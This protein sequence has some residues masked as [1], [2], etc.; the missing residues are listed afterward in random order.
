MS[1]LQSKSKDLVK[2][3]ALLHS[4]RLF[5]SVAHCAYYSC[6]Q[7][8]KHI[9]LHRMGKTAEELKRQ[10]SSHVHLIR[11]VGEAIKNSDVTSFYAFRDKI[12]KLKKLRTDADYSDAPFD[13]QKSA[14]ALSLLRGIAP[15]LKKHC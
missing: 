14:N 10:R 11:L 12:A 15:I 5:P 4:E 1:H 7:L 13:A 8:M 6:V 9:W 3:A 2:A